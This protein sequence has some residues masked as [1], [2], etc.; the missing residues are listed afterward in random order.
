MYAQGGRVMEKIET[1]RIAFITNY[2]HLTPDESKNFWP[3]YGQYTENM[4]HI[5]KDAIPT[6]PLEDMNDQEADKAISTMFEKENKLLD[7]KKDCLLKL[8]K[9]LPSRKIAL[10]YKAEIEFKGELLNAIKERRQER[11]L[12]RE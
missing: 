6:K 3:V 11:R 5:K 10:L 8:R 12:N 2:L 1:Q 4:K 7:L 9:V